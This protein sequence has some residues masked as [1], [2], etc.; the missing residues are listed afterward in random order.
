M[1]EL[2]NK[3]NNHSIG[4]LEDLI[5]MYLVAI[6]NQ[7]KINIKLNVTQKNFNVYKIN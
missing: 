7:D 1:T 6:D 4:N 2:E 3:N 5:Q